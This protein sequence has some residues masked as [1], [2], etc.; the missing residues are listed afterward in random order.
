MERELEGVVHRE[1]KEPSKGLDL[2]VGPEGAGRPGP[3]VGDF[4]LIIP[5]NHGFQQGVI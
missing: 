4:T 5:E 3:A 2:K 1:A